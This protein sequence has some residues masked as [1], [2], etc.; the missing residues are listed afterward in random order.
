MDVFSVPEVHIGK[1]T[2]TVWFSV[3]TATAA[4]L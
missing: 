3:W 4:T 2:L 1:E